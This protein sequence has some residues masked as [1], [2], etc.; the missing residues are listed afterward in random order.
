MPIRYGSLQ[1]A[2]TV[3]FA[4]SF[5]MCALTLLCRQIAFSTTSLAA[6]ILPVTN[7]TYVAKRA[8]CPLTEKLQNSLGDTLWPYVTTI[9][10]TEVSFGEAICEV[11][12]VTKRG[13]KYT[14]D[15]LCEVEGEPE[16]QTMEWIVVTRTSFKSDGKTFVLCR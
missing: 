3:K 12:K 14:L 5:A 15:A 8:Y 1:T 6:S 16:E 13:A 2:V 7:G 10:N 9:K 11:T 4:M